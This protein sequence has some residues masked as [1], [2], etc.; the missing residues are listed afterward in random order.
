MLAAF[1]F[2]IL[3]M[4]NSKNY[5]SIVFLT[6]LS[7]YLGLVLVGGTSPVLAQAALTQKITEVQSKAKDET[8]EKDCWDDASQ[9]VIDLLN[10][11]F[12]TY[13]ILEFISDIQNLTKIGK[14]E[15]D[16]RFDLQFEYKS[17]EG[18]IAQTSYPNSYSGSK[19]IR[20]AGSERVE[21][22]TLNSYYRYDQELK[23]NTSHSKVSFTSE[24]GNLNIK[25]SSEFQTSD[26]ASEFAKFYNKTFEVGSCSKYIDDKEK[27]IYENTKALSENN[28]VFIVTR[29]PRGSLDA[30]LANKD[31][32]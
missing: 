7:V 26:S 18:G 27:I 11:D 3:G 16:E 28:Q 22:L 32:Q 29:L 25:T 12:L 4:S 17:T 2:S 21:G 10:S 1:P 13:Q 9:D 23:V 19:W 6:T 30:L 20:L 8:D 14:Y 24:N 5:N 15:K 31:A